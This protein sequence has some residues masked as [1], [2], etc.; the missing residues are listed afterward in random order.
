MEDFQSLSTPLNSDKLLFTMP[1]NTSPLSLDESLRYA[2]HLSLQ[3]IGEQG[4]MR[5]KAARVLCIG[6][7]GLGSS[8]L[9]YLASAGVGHIGIVDGDCVELSN[10]QRQILHSESSLGMNKAMSAAMALEQLNSAIHITPYPYELHASNALELFSHYDIILDGTDNFDTR[11]CINDAAFLAQ[12]TN[13]HAAITHFSGYVACFAPHDKT[14]CYR[15]L[16]PAPPPEGSIPSCAQAG[17]LGVIPG[18]IGS[19]QALLTLRILLHL[20]EN[21]LGRLTSYDGLSG[22]MHTMELTPN[23]HCH[24]CTQRQTPVLSSFFSKKT[25]SLIQS[26]SPQDLC[27]QLDSSPPPILI[28]IREES[29]WGTGHLP[30]AQHLPFSTIN[31]WHL[32]FLSHL[33]S[34]L[35]LYC[36]SGMRS[37]RACRFL[38]DKGFT[39]LAQLSGGIHAWKHAGLPLHTSLS[40]YPITP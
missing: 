33:D 27:N 19:L 15:C 11:Y 25:P 6:A 24:L 23:P 7:G 30:H 35:I 14:A 1:Q 32:S 4:Q 34:P 21:P 8:A 39:H 31:Q 17:V 18:V 12:K 20:G 36:H 26:L 22:R 3:E 28:D 38:S 10:L 2:R 37:K 29:E 5:L 9:F 16:H 13:I 40:T